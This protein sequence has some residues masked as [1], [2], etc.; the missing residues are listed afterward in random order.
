MK[1]NFYK[2]N[3]RVLCQ[4]LLTS[5]GFIG[6]GKK[7][8]FNV[9]KHLLGSRK[10]FSVYDVEKSIVVYTKVLGLVTFFDKEG[11]KILFLGSP[12][13]LEDSVKG[14]LAKSKHVYLSKESWK[15]GIFSNRRIFPDLI[16][17]FKQDEGFSS[18]ECLNKNI[19]LVSF[20]EK[21]HKRSFADFSVMVNLRSVGAARMFF[22]LIKQLTLSS[23]VKC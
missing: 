23:H 13:F 10:S 17:S 19:P 20:V 11:L 15:P 6:K 18:K 22:N 3:N 12:F 14:L 2:S 4:E 16:V 7:K 21:T 8:N 5:G 1:K 9:K